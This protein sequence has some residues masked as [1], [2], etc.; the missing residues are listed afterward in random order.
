MVPAAHIF[1]GASVEQL[2]R[3]RRWDPERIRRLRNALLKRFEP[4]AVARAT[5]PP[6]A[7]IDLHT[8]S[9]HARHDSSVDG[10]TKLILRN[11]AN[12]LLEAVV[13]RIASGRSTLCVSSQVGCAAACRFCATGQMGMAKDLSTAEILDQV[14]HGGQLLAAEGRTLRNIVFMGMGEPLH[15]EKNLYAAL[16][17]LLHP[18]WFHLPASKILVS[19]VG[20]LEPMVRFA[21]R[22]PDVGLAVSLHSVR[23]EVRE[24]LIPL[25]KK[26]PLPELRRVLAELQRSQGRRVMLEYLMLD[27]VNDTPEDRAALLDWTDGLDAHINLIPYNP[28]DGAPTLRPSAAAVGSEFAEALKRAGRK[29]TVRRSLGRDIAAACGQLV[30]RDNL[31][32]LRSGPG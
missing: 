2:R 27:G 31:A 26:N 28:I 15:N 1:D 29:T 23:T 21:E 4:D 24:R 19:T 16:D 12:L 25:A 10:A 7:A 3:Q 14:V 5:L 6:D 18:A 9:P 17:A 30:E 13:L 8:L 22:F 32:R 20:V 11:A